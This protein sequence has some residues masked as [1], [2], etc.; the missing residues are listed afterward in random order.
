MKTSF[1]IQAKAQHTAN[2]L[3]RIADENPN[4]SYRTIWD[5]FCYQND[6]DESSEG[7]EAY[8]FDNWVKYKKS[9]VD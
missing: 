8:V 5:I 9:L 2:E 4:E 3:N 6:V 7:V 1:Y